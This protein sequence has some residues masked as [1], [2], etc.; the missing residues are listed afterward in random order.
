[1][2][3]EIVQDRRISPDIRIRANFDEATDYIQWQPIDA[4]PDDDAEWRTEGHRVCDAAHQPKRALQ[5]VND[6]LDAQG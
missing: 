6:Y 1:M 2:A 4:D 5:L 3:K